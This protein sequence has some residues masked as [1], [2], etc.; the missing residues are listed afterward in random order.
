MEGLDCTGLAV[1][2]DVVESL[3]V[4]TKGKATKARVAV[5]VYCRPLSQQDDI[6]IYIS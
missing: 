1:G 4:R 2:D 3:W 6:S 5:G